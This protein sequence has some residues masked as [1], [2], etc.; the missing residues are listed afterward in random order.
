MSGCSAGSFP[1]EPFWRLRWRLVV[2]VAVAVE[3]ER[4]EAHAENYTE[5]DSEPHSYI[6]GQRHCHV[7][8]IPT[9]ICD[10]DC[11]YKQREQ[12]RNGDPS[13]HARLPK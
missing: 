8:E 12:N 3:H 9:Y 2:P 11:R 4:H 6:A 1:L 5:D 10:V 7:G 13:S